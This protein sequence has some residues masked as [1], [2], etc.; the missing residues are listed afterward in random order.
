MSIKNSATV[1]MASLVALAGLAA[2][3]GAVAAE[4]AGAVQEVTVEAA[5]TTTTSAGRTGSGVPIEIT[6]L[7]YAVNY[8]DLDLS[9]QT[10]IGKLETRVGA[11]AAAGCKELEKLLPM[12]KPDPSCAKKA[13]D[14]AMVQVRAVSLSASERARAASDARAKALGQPVGA[15]AV[16]PA[17]SV[18][19]VTVV[20]M[21]PTRTTVGRTSS[22]AA[23]ELI[24]VQHRVSYAD[25]Y[26][27]TPSGEASLVNRVNDAAASACREIEEIH[28]TESKDANCA[29][30]AGDGAM[31]QVRAAIDAAKA[32]AGGK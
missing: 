26:L 14:D 9:T 22:G 17:A 11:A 27:A 29:K 4:Q 31:S 18:Q 12:G 2:V 32:K 25:L 15:A 30:K 13:T 1:G 6:Q 5:R 28:P 7:K 8:A 19:E 10:G 24:E 21:R 20:A 16:A 23:V 3:G